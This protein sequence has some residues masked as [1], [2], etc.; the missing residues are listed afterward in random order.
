MQYPVL[1]GRDGWTRFKTLSHCSLPRN[2]DNAPLLVDLELRFDEVGPT[3]YSRNPDTSTDDARFHLVCVGDEDAFVSGS[4]RH[5]R[6]LPS[7]GGLATQPPR[8]T[9]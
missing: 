8:A 5:S 3:A 6:L 9:T 4:P 1:L 7:Y 2:S